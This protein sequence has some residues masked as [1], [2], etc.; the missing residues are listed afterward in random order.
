MQLARSGK[1]IKR[2][3]RRGVSDDPKKTLRQT[4]HLTQPVQRVYLQLGPG[5]CC[6]PEHCID[7]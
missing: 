3:G 5:W 6:P 7:V 2:V 1:R 4:H